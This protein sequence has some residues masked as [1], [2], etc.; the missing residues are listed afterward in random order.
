MSRFA[1]LV[2]TLDSGIE[3]FAH[4]RWRT[5]TDV[6]SGL[7]RTQAALVHAIADMRGADLA[8]RDGVQAQMFLSLVQSPAFW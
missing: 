8:S 6:T 5:L 1:E 3:K 7:L 4:W 2:K